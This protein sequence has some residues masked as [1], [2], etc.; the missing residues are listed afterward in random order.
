[1]TTLLLL[2]QTQVHPVVQVLVAAAAACVLMAV[3]AAL[4][5]VAERVLVNYGTCTIDVNQGKET[6]EIEGG[7]S[8]LASLKSQNIFIPSAC[9]GRGT[10]AYCKVK[11]LDGGG[12]VTPTEEPLLTSEEIADQVRI[13]CQV[14]VR[15]DMK[16][17]IPEE[18]FAIQAFR[19]RVERIRD[20]THD[21][22][23]V[24]IEL[25]EPETID[26]IPGQYIQLEA[27]PYGDNPESVYRAYSISSVPSDK[28]HVEMIIRL[29]PG[30]ICT[31][32]VFEHLKEG[33]EVNLN[34]PYGEFR[35][36]DDADRD[37]VWIAGGSGMAPFWSLV[38]HMKEQ[39]IERPCDYFFGAVSQ[40]DLFLVEELE[41]L[42]EELPWF[43][44]VPALSGDDVGDWS[45][46][47]GLITE[48]VGR[49]IEDGSNKEGYLC[50][51]AGMIDASIKVLESK[52]ITEQ[53]IYYDKFN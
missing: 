43:R 38:R 37:M 49:N 29:V 39:G 1:M 48:A 10:C 44:F 16:I 32:W 36:S 25:I 18:L 52:G 28:S 42:A 13:S 15:N 9:G 3:L 27:P 14:K 5:L 11:I 12:P 35:L 40:R 53:R 47:R 20:L 21:I 6:F 33:D 31:T 41:Q 45:G 34:G 19:G 22:K 4:L 46:E 51:S 17:Q 7:E 8:L 23:E 26:F 2:A 50:G 30:G 24:R